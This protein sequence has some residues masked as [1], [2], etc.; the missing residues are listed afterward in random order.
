MNIQVLIPMIDNGHKKVTVFDVDGKVIEKVYNY[1]RG[2]GFLFL[3]EYDS[4][5]YYQRRMFSTGGSRTIYSSTMPADCTE[6][7]RKVEYELMKNSY[8]KT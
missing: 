3:V 1:G 7:G 2:W 8:Q 6:F 4:I 5:E